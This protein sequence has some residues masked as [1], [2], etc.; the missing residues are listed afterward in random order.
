MKAYNQPTAIMAMIFMGWAGVFFTGLKPLILSAYKDQ[1]GFGDE[2]VGYLV[3][4]ETSGNF[5]GALFAASRI[6]RWD[7]RAMGV[8]ALTVMLIGNI[9][10]FPLTTFSTLAPVRFLV[11]C[12]EGLAMG[13]MAGTMAGT[14]KPDRNFAIYTAAV[15]L[16]VTAGFIVIPLFLK[17]FGMGGIFVLLILLLVPAAITLRF[18]PRFGPTALGAKNIHGF[19][20]DLPVGKTVIVI[21]G[22]IIAYLGIG[23]FSPF[24][25]EIGKVSGLQ[26]QF[27]ANVLAFVQFCGFLGALLAAWQGLRW[28]RMRPAVTGL[29]AMTASVAAVLV[30]PASSLV[31]IVSMSVFLFMWLYFFAYLAGITSALDPSGRVTALMFTTTSIGFA[32][33][34]AMNGWL[35]EHTGGYAAVELVTIIFLLSSIA[36]LAPIARGQDRE[37]L[38]VQ[39]GYEK[40]KF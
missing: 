19:F 34:P 8:A 29:L 27:R 1:L 36:L 35:A 14:E 17:I 22:S 2:L 32:A 38:V 7:R 39:Q 11:G 10:S 26:G 13:V 37:L 28:G 12:G 9:G 5:F 18:F 4:I 33:G 20:E 31:F 3:A 21:I 24:M 40:S 30:I 16:A 23:G 6:H 25:A 15:L